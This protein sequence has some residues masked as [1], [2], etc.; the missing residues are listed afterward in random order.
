MIYFGLM[1]WYHMNWYDIMNSDI[2]IY[3]YTVHGNSPVRNLLV[4]TRGAVR[5]P[6]SRVLGVSKGFCWSALNL[7]RWTP[8]RPWRSERVG[9]TEFNSQLG[10]TNCLEVKKRSVDVKNGSS[11]CN[12]T[13]RWKKYCRGVSILYS[14]KL[15]VIQLSQGV[16]LPVQNRTPFLKQGQLQPS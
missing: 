7:S 12:S 10:L 2:F 15:G 5:Q 8:S 1:I 4:K 6:A 16:G 11:G 14:K 3:I 9:D 13:S